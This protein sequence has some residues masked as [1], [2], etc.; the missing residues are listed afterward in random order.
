MPPSPESGPVL[1]VEDDDALRLFLVSVLEQKGYRVISAGTGEEAL[2]LLG[3]QEA[4][5]AV[6]DIG[7]PGM[8]GF[9]VAEQLA[10]EVPVIIVTGDPVGAYARVHTLRHEFQVLPK[11]VTPELLEHAVSSALVPAP[12]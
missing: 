7:L 11:P 9:A 10:D 3:E 12:A 5:V 1:V 4:R 8:D 2:A 6:L